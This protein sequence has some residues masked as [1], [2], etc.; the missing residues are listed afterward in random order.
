[1]NI[2][3]I[4][5]ALVNTGWALLSFNNNQINYISSGVI[6]TIPSDEIHLRLYK[7]YHEIENIIKLYNPTA[8]AIEET[9]INKNATSSLKLG[10]VRGVILS[11][12]GKYNMTLLEFKPNY[13]KKAVVGIGHAEKEQIMHMIKLI[14]P[15]IKSIKSSDEADA[16]AIAY[17]GI[18]SINNMKLIL[19]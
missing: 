1:M 18:V 2:L 3:G 10:Y 17:T 6:R 16:L 4:D 8:M 11:L 13:I 14:I 19:K 12:A 9:F 7:I 5:P 15:S